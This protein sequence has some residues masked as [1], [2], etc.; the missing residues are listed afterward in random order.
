VGPDVPV[1]LCVERSL[2]MVVGLLG[3]LKAGG[4]YVPLDPTYPA[5]RLAFMVDDTGVRVLLTQAHLAPPVTPAVICLDRDW[6]VIAECSAENPAPLAGPMDL[7]YLIYTS[8][9]TGLPKA[10]AVPHRAV[11]RLVKTTAY[12]AFGPDEVTLQF[13]PLAFDASTFE[14]WGA[15]LN[16]GRLVVMPP[17]LPSLDELGR[18]VQD[19]GV[20]TLWLTAGLFHQ[21]IETAADS[22]RGVRQLLAGGDVLSPVHVRQALATLPGCQIINGYGP[23]E[24]TTFTCCHRLTHRDEVGT[25]VPIGRP[26]ANTRVYV[27]DAAGAPVPVGVAGELYIGGDGLARGYWRRPELTAARFVASALDPDGRLYRTGDLVRWRADGVLEFLGRQDGQVKIRGFRVEVGEIEA[28]LSD[29]IAVQQ[30]VVVAQDAEVGGKRLVA[31][32]VGPPE[33][34][35]SELRAYVRQRLPEYLVPSHVVVLDAFPLTAN[36]KVDRAALPVPV[37]TKQ[38]T[39]EQPTSELEKQVASVW[40]AVLRMDSVST[41]DNFFDIG[42]HSLLLAHLHSRLQTTLGRKFP[43]LDLFRNPTVRSFAAA[44]TRCEHHQDN[45]AAVAR[46][47][48]QKQATERLRRTRVSAN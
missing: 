1:G 4:A 11:V 6:A 32:V 8:G 18:A 41:D 42:G 22:L 44:L 33:T 46:A 15:L 26:I 5:E 48:R 16:G 17:Q 9:S 12:A 43:L 2:E 28:V 24:N 25:T 30:V 29:H 3:I 14:I 37:P 39:N 34:L 20:T 40:A 38:T 23:T 31:Y 7:A 19:G 10:V 35:A 27:L 21:M 36:G 45:A 47:E 13:A